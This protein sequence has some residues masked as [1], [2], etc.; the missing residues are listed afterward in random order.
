MQINFRAD[1]VH[2]KNPETA[3]SQKLI[4]AKRLQLVLLLSSYSVNLPGVPCTGCTNNWCNVCAK[5]KI[6]ALSMVR[7]PLVYFKTKK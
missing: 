6:K 1:Y 7:E 4:H 2:A 3:E 5:T